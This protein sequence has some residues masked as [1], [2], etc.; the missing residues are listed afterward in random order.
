VAS[1]ISAAIKGDPSFQVESGS[2]RD[3]LELAKT[4]GRALRPGD[5]LAVLG[6]LGAGKTVFVKG[7]AEAFDCRE[8]VTSPTFVLLQTYKPKS[9][10]WPFHHAD[11]Y[12]LKPEETTA[13]DWEELLSPGGVTAVEW[14]EKALPFWPPHCL[15]VRITHAP[16][17]AGSPEGARRVGF[18][19]VGPRSS[20]LTKR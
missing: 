4:L 18:Y 14:A 13:L 1:N 17:G 11:L 10:R 20:E 16:Q 3:T 5:W 2:E 7:L 12:R 6:E 8:P 15:P 19:A 9:G